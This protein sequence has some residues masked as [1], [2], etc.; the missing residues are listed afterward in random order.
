MARKRRRPGKRGR[1]RKGKRP[2][3]AQ[4]DGQIRFLA[5]K[6]IPD[7]HVAASLVTMVTDHVRTR[8]ASLTIAAGPAIDP[9]RARFHS[10]LPSTGGFVPGGSLKGRADGIFHWGVGTTVNT[11]PITRKGGASMTGVTAAELRVAVS[12]LLD[13]AACRG[14]R[15][16]VEHGARQAVRQPRRVG[17]RAPSAVARVAEAGPAERRR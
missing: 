14:D 6:G 9:L 11:G 3:K 4:P 7:A 8:R 10:L 2:R 13:R 16:A 17:S 12:G 1:R 5:R 15:V